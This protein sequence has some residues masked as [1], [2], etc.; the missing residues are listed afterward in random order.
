MR[1]LSK[2]VSQK[3]LLVASIISIDLF[4][5]SALLYE[6]DMVPNTIFRAILIAWLAAAI[7]MSLMMQCNLR[8]FS[9]ESLEDVWVQRCYYL[10]G[11]VSLAGFV[12]LYLEVV[13][14]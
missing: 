4:L 7:I 1:F 9:R 8:A 5:G 6:F 11:V 14:S 2:L 10:G 12:A 3:S 13:G